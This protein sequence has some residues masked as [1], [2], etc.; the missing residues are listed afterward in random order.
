MYTVDS[1]HPAVVAD[2]KAAAQVELDRV[3]GLYQSRRA[4]W[5]SK[6]GTSLEKIFFDDAVFCHQIYQQTKTAY[7]ALGITGSIGIHQI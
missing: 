1:L 3:W 7:K 4:D 6:V 2:L 5:E